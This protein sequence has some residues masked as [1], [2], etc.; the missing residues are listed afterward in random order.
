MKTPEGVEKNIASLKKICNATLEVRKASILPNERR[1][2][3]MM[4]WINL[5]FWIMKEK[6]LV[7]ILHLLNWIVMVELFLLYKP[8]LINLMIDCFVKLNDEKLFVFGLL[9]G[10]F[11][12]FV[13]LY[14]MLFILN[15]RDMDLDEVN[16]WIVFN[17]TSFINTILYVVYIFSF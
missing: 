14:I 2:T 5:W 8:T 11:F 12:A 16:D 13:G 10:V 7:N 3:L 17:L 6:W 1:C 4:E 15:I 9:A